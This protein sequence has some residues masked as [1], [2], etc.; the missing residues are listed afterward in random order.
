MR[1]LIALVTFLTLLSSLAHATKITLDD[2][3]TGQADYYKYDNFIGDVHLKVD[4]KP[5]DFS[6]YNSN[7]IDADVTKNAGLGL[8]V[9]NDIIFNPDNSRALEH[10]EGLVFHFSEEVLI[11]GFWVTPINQPD[12]Y[13]GVTDLDNNMITH[14]INDEGYVNF[15]NGPMSLLGF[16]ITGLVNCT[17]LYVNAIETP[18]AVPLPAAL[19][20]YGAGVGLLG[21]LG[22][23]R[24][25]KQKQ[26]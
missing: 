10:G 17:G 7:V 21:L 1:K 12:S 6:I 9:D 2:G 13:F 15:E 18:S 8:G 22:W 3:T 5:D 14:S 20:L 25:R 23:Q 16:I 26:A 24:K 4:A 19:P 11:S